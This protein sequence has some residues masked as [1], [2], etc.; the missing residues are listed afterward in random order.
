MPDGIRTDDVKT[1][2]R[3]TRYIGNLGWRR[4][5]EKQLIQEWSRKKYDVGDVGHRIHPTPRNGQDRR[6]VYTSDTRD[7]L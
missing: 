4:G 6:V 7:D 1:I 5:F 2:I 3:N